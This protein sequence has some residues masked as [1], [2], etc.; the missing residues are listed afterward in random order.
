MINENPP[1]AQQFPRETSFILWGIKENVT[2]L[3]KSEKRESW[4][5]PD[6]NLKFKGKSIYCVIFLTKKQTSYICYFV[7]IWFL[8]IYCFFW[9]VLLSLHWVNLK[10]RSYDCH[11]EICW[12]LPWLMPPPP[13]QSVRANKHHKLTSSRLVEFFYLCFCRVHN[14]CTCFL[15]LFFKV[16]TWLASIPH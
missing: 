14:V 15:F 8:T 4:S 1:G 16:P 7:I 2:M 9:T 12:L 11:S 10:T 6:P 13:P 5:A 3:K